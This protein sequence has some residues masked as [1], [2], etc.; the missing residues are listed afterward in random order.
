MV[1]AQH[2]TKRKVEGEIASADF[3][4]GHFMKGLDHLLDIAGF[5]QHTDVYPGMGQQW[6][7]FPPKREEG[8]HETE[9][10][11][12]LHSCPSFL[13]Y[14]VLKDVKGVLGDD[15]WGGQPK[16]SV[17]RWVL[18]T[19]AEMYKDEN[20]AKRNINNKGY[21]ILNGVPLYRSPRTFT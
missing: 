17:A 1:N 19:L 21:G 9:F 13:L 12:I 2:M 3:V 7:W 20:I 4:R 15:R 16:R 10:A 5:A 11:S 18:D 14:C 8:G 6:A